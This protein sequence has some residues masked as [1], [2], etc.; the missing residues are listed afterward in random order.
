VVAK[1]GEIGNDLGD[2]LLVQDG[3]V[4][5][6]EVHAIEDS[7][8]LREGDNHNWL[9]ALRGE[10]VFFSFPLDVDF[11]ML[12]AFPDAYQQPK[13]GGQG[14]RGDANAI[15]DKKLVTL[16]T[17]GSP[18]LY[19]DSYVDEFKW[20]P[21]LFLNRS[22]PETHIAALSLIEEEGLAENAPPELEA[23]IEHVQD[24][25]GLEDVDE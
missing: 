3:T 20:Y 17:G 19:E 22:K 21:Y 9:R 4:D 11:A 18:E 15:R 7:E 6:T 13:P 23:L 10:G 1:L 8:L 16:K 25:L 2:N 14:P 5:P 24:A 12:R